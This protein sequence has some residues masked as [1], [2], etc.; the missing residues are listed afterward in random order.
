M[1]SSSSDNADTRTLE[2]LGYSQD[3]LRGLGTIE[4]FALGF[5]QLGGWLVVF[6]VIFY[7]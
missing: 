2:A 5:A 1:D 7:T 6:V 4:A 3:L